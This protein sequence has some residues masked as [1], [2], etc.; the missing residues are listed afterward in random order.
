[1]ASLGVNY[2][3][4]AESGK[5][6]SRVYFQNGL[7]SRNHTVQKVIYVRQ[8]EVGK[9]CETEIVYLKVRFGH[10][11]EVTLNFIVFYIL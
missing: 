1:M 5:K 10:N 3:L 6:Y 11:C 4:E 9:H 7:E 8:N 2:T